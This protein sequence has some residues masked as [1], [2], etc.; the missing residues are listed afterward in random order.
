MTTT[1]RQRQRAVAEQMR[2]WISGAS[3]VPLDEDRRFT[4]LDPVCSSACGDLC[5]K[6]GYRMTPIPHYWARGKS[7]FPTFYCPLCNFPEMAKAIALA[8]DKL[9]KFA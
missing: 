8:L 6:C 7:W 3:L 9:K 4:W 1:A 5:S 2:D